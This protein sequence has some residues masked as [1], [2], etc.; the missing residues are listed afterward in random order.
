[1]LS[2]FGSAVLFLGMVIPL[3][4]KPETDKEVY[5]LDTSKAMSQWDL[6]GKKTK[7]KIVKASK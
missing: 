6:E 3:N 2:T 1:M 5:T 7:N 4:G